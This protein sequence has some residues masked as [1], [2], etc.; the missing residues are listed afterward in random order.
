VLSAPE[1]LALVNEIRAS[2][3]LPQITD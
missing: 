1:L 2:E 3:G